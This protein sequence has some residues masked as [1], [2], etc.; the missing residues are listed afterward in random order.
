[1]NIEVLPFTFNRFENEE[2]VNIEKD[3][4][5]ALENAITVLKEK[6]NELL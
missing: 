4:C 6:K 1:A 2:H 5:K 3:V